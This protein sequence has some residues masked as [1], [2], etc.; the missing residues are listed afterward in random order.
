MISVLRFFGSFGFV[1][2][3]ARFPGARSSPD[4]H[5]SFSILSLLRPKVSRSLL[6]SRF[7]LDYHLNTVLSRYKEFPRSVR[8]QGCLHSIYGVSL[9]GA[10]RRKPETT[11]SLD[12]G[13]RSIPNRNLISR[14]TCIAPVPARSSLRSSLPY[15]FIALPDSLVDRMTIPCVSNP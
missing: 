10:E 6:R 8:G 12:A 1:S 3:S 4:Y 2:S 7:K 14:Q 11:S 5:F 9:L 15:L 13:S